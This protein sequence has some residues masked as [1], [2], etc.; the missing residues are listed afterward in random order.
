M[1]GRSDHARDAAETALRLGIAHHERA[2]QAEA[3]RLLGELTAAAGPAGVTQG[4]RHLRQA[5]SLAGEVGS[6]PLTAR[7]RLSL[8]ALAG[9]RG[10]L[11]QAREHL[12]AA[13]GLCAAMDLR[14]PLDRVRAEIDAPR[15]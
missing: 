7:C 5:L 2:H 9:Q 13:E 12:A 8:A 14:L 4:E 3:L 10:D 15:P 1:A 6:P 11:D